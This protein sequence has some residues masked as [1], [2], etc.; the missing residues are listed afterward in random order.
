[1]ENVMILLL[2]ICVLPIILIFGIAFWAS[3]SREKKQKALLD[4]VPHNAEFKVA[5]R[6]N[7]GRTQSQIFKLKAF[8]GSGVLYLL[9]NKIH[10]VTTTNQ[11]DNF[12]FDLKTS[13]INWTGVNLTNGLLE[14]FQIKNGNLDYYFN[15]ETGLFIF[16]TDSTKIK[17]SQV[18]T[19]LK[20]AQK[21]ISS[22]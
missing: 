6:Y 1:M 18:C 12:T 11:K 22:F 16:H 20:E 5:L 14:W 15:V 10:F 13:Q 8:Q 4:Q 21:R 19:Y 7:F 2:F 9:D 17:T 3:K